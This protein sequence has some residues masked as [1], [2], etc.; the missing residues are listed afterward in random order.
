MNTK[1]NMDIE[2]AKRD[3]RKE[4]IEGGLDELKDLLADG[5]HR[6]LGIDKETWDAEEFD[7][8]CM[9]YDWLF[10]KKQGLIKFVREK[11]DKVDHEKDIIIKPTEKGKKFLNWLIKQDKKTRL[12]A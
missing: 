6:L 5:E 7:P 12:K 8:H 3:Y 4:V 1:N 10:A 11:E 2:K 9:L